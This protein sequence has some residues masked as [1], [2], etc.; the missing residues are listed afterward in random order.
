MW[1]EA[2]WFDESF[3]RN[4]LARGLR[5]TGNDNRD[6][7]RRRARIGAAALVA[8]AHALLIYLLIRSSV[9]RP[10]PAAPAVVPIHVS[11]IAQTRQPRFSR[12]SRLRRPKLAMLQVSSKQ[13]IPEF[14]VPAPPAPA[15]SAGPIAHSTG[16]PARQGEIGRM[17][18]PV[19]LRIVHYVVP[20]IPF[21]RDRC[22]VKG[23]IVMA[24]R[25]D[26]HWGVG[27]VKILR[28]TGS[29]L[30]DRSAVMAVRKWK[31]APLEGVAPRKPI[32]VEVP[33]HFAPPMR[34]S[35]VPIIMPYQALPQDFDADML[36]SH[37]GSLHAPSAADSVHRLLQKIIT[38]FGISSGQAS[39]VDRQCIGDTPAAKLAGLGPLRSEKFLGFV[40]H[41]VSI[42]GSE[43][44]AVAH[45]EAYKI[46]Q[47][48]GSSVWLV[49]ATINGAI[50]QIA[51]AIR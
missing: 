2:T 27:G 28:S 34:I 45:W 21:V 46:V 19:A 16:S 51:V 14:R 22:G 3:M 30:L 43:S 6:A 1:T 15:L 44:S 29:A 20:R 32:W 18:G 35:G 42:E 40:K 23:R 37:H 12:P 31:F 47:A 7:S 25:L 26:A 4:P 48:H 13:Q 9:T 39:G 8:A 33:I 38:E 5:P 10:T 24:V 11:L 49:L 50:Q 36:M 41:G 17:S